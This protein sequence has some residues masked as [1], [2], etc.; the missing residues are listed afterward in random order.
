MPSSASPS[1]LAELQAGGENLNTWGDTRLNTAL[2]MLEAA[3]HGITSHTLTSSKALSYTNF[4]AT[5]GTDYV[6]KIA[7][8]SD[9]SY[10]LTLG[11]YERAYLIWNDSSH[12]QTI[13]CSGGGTSVT[14]FAGQAMPVYCDGTNVIRH[15]GRTILNGSGAPSA[16][17]GQNGDYWIDNDASDLY[18]PK[19]DGAWPSEATNLI[20]PQGAGVRVL[21]DLASVGDLPETGTVS[22]AYVINND[23]YVWT[24]SAWED[25]GVFSLRVELRNNGTHV[26]WRYVN[27]VSWTNLF[28]ISG[29]TVVSPAGEVNFFAV[30]PGDGWVECNGQ[31]LTEASTLRT[32]LLD[33]GSPFGTSGSDP[34]VPDIGGRVIAGAEAS[35]SRLSTSTI[36]GT[37]TSVDGSTVGATGGSDRASISRN[38]SFPSGYQAASPGVTTSQISGF[39][40]IGFLNAAGATGNG[41]I[42]NVQPTII[43]HA[44]IRLEPANSAPAGPQG[45]QGEKGDP[46][47]PLGAVTQQAGTTYTLALTDAEDM[48]EF[49]SSSAVTVTIPTNASVAFD[50]GSVIHIAQDGTGAV[51]IQ[52]D[53]GVT[54]KKSSAVNATLA[55]QHSVAT[56]AKV[57]TDTWRLFGDLELA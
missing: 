9:G 13:A 20:G 3:G 45:V 30:A 1:V 43:L 7:S 2:Q 12:D 38:S 16:S 49:T 18:G 52:G 37:N 46:G 54:V 28:A 17:D 41:N 27:E 5:D 40:G 10:T 4:T 19:A 55:G 51:A 24:G 39:D 6:Q 11:G 32:E 44:Y 15:G 42:S 21:G 29:D 23:V 53:G 57:A 22:D 25:L 50:V 56:V 31:A 47:A 48:V 35:A 36:D 14:V 33:A 26:Q 8:G 34:R